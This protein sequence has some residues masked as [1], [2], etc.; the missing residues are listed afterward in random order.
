MFIL[1]FLCSCASRY[2]AP[3][4]S[5]SINTS[6]VEDGQIKLFYEAA[7][8]NDKGNYAKNARQK[9]LHFVQVIV[10]NKSSEDI[11]LTMD[12]IQAFT[13]YQPIEVVSPSEVK[14]KL[15]QKRG[16]YFLYLIPG[17]YLTTEGFTYRPVLAPVGIYNFIRATNANK[18]LNDNFMGDS[19]IG[20]EVR[21][22]EKAEGWICIQ[23]KEGLD[24]VLL[25]YVE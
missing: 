21:S 2:V 15:K 12:N 18:K 16:W 4:S 22:G 24:N 17:A 9:D 23:R 13:E 20:K 10:I 25:R 11:L 6:E 7:E 3:F 1:L 8:L 14:K 19:L 5:P